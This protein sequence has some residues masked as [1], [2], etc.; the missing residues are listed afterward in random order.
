MDSAIQNRTRLLDT[1]PP[2][3]LHDRL[4]SLWHHEMGD[5]PELGIEF[6]W[7]HEMGDQP[8]LGCACVVWC[9]DF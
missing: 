2:Q 5:Q 1:V 6:T 4:S 8:E 9:S 7:L 3:C